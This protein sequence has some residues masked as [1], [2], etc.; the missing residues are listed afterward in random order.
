MIIYTDHSTLKHLLYKAESKPRLIRCVLLL[1]E[2]ALE[3]RNK[4]DTENVVAVHLSRLPTPLRKEG[5]CDLP[6]GNSF[7]N[8][9]LI[10]LAVLSAPWFV[11]LVNYLA[12]GIIPPNMNSHQRKQFFSQAKSCLRGTLFIQ[13]MWG[14]AYSPMCARRRNYFHYFPL[15]WQA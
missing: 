10:T 12:C 5:E 1:Q 14:W 4:K 13:G 8:D 7:P 11:D 6:I 3:I 2:F 15:P 9:Y